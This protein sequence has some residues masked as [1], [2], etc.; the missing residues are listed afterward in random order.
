MLVVHKHPD[1]ELPERYAGS[2]V[3]DDDAV[4]PHELRIVDLDTYYLWKDGR[5]YVFAQRTDGTI[6]HVPEDECGPA[7]GAAS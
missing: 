1:V 2:L 3:C 6:V 5:R 7:E 4:P